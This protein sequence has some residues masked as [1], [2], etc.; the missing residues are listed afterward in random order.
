MRRIATGYVHVLL[1]IPPGE[2]YRLE[3]KD[4][5]SMVSYQYITTGSR[6]EESFVVLFFFSLGETVGIIL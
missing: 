6:A 3:R 2:S 4:T 5:D 1:L